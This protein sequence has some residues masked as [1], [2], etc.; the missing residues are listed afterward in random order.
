MRCVNLIEYLIEIRV[1]SI[2]LRIFWTDYNAIISVYRKHGIKHVLSFG[3]L[4]AKK[5]PKMLK[6][7]AKMDVLRLKTE[8]KM[9][10]LIKNEVHF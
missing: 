4:I 5:H 8:A 3:K 9:N 2:I 1:E 10:I 6:T 7:E